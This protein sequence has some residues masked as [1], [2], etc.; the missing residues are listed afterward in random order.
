MKMCIPSKQT[1]AI[2]YRNVRLQQK[3]IRVDYV[4]LIIH[5]RNYSAI[6]S[7][8]RL[9]IGYSKCRK[10]RIIKNT[11]AILVRID[12]FSDAPGRAGLHFVIIFCENEM[13]RI[14]NGYVIK[15]RY[16]TI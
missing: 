1:H 10:W 12:I 2:F 8:D 13:Y 11:V 5:G 7:L 4:A 16:N 9:K 6:Y 3:V 14:F 15:K